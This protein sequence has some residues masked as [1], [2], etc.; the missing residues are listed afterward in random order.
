[1]MSLQSWVISRS[2]AT[3]DRPEREP[4]PHRQGAVRQAPGH[5]RS[6]L[7]H[8]ASRRD[9]DSQLPPVMARLNLDQFSFRAA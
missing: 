3:I 2:I 8:S 7:S 4:P 1:M 9:G 5:R 6:A